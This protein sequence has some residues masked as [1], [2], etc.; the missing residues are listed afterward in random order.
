[1]IA[2]ATLV[3]AGLRLFH[4]GAQSL[5]IDE[6]L[7]WNSAHIGKAFG[8]SELLENVH[9][10]LFS[11]I[12][13]YWC[14]WASDSE[15]A[16]RLPSVLFGVATVPAIAWLAGRWLG[17]P[18]AV[19]AAWL[20]AL[21]PFH[22][23]YSQEARNYS[24]LMLC[25]CVSGALALDLRERLTVRGAALY[26]A[27]AWAGL[28]SNLSFAFPFPLH[29]AWALGPRGQRMRR[30]A[31]AGVVALVVLAAAIPWAPQA[32]RI[33][34]WQRLHPG[35]AVEH[36][37]ARLRGATT[38]HAAAVP[39]AA[40]AFAVG[41][42]LGPSLRELRADHSFATV[43]RHAPGIAVVTLVFAALG[44]LGLLSLRRRGRLGEALLWLLPPLAVVCW[45]AVANFKVFHPRYL[46]V[47]FPMFVL[48]LA[49]AFADLRP[50]WR[51]VLAGAVLALWLRSLWVLY[52]DPHYGKEDY[53][54][55]SAL[56]ARGAVAGEKVLAV[57]TADELFY[58]YRGPL[59]IESF[60][61]G[62]AAD[63]ER[64]ELKLRQAMAGASGRWVVLSRS[65]DQDPT[66][67]FVRRFEA[68]YPDA[69]RWQL[70]GIRVWHVAAPAAAAERAAPARR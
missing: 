6:V 61:L 32:T 40:H 42:T 25:A 13:H 39:F 53:R 35:R 57:N 63:P 29:L 28:L 14:G 38:F 16:L 55:A 31:L 68:T 49:A 17:R 66:G 27:T 60:W 62:Y 10:P 34:D 45:F 18:V 33:W 56:I 3:A 46:A 52:F 50:R 12:E 48:V 24:L 5:W 54:S 59:P 36:G 7:T 15:W 26:V 30:A 2:A 11:L 51:G 22:V 69:G 19:W 37:E 9:G 58:Y 4:L 65:E 67:S 8:S 64:L 20:L 41:Y 44:L 21:S 43:R 1:M 47:A 23:W 70:E